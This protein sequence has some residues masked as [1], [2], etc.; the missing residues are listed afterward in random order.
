MKTSLA[1]VNPRRRRHP[2]HQPQDWPQQG[3]RHARHLWALD[4][5]LRRA[6]AKAIE[7]MLK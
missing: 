5:R 3:E 7:G 2:H 1:H 6:A 4:R